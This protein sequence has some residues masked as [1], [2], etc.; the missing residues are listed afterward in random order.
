MAT[1]RPNCLVRHN[2]GTG[3]RQ[4]GVISGDLITIVDLEAIGWTDRALIQ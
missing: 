2:P 1:L 4:K 3:T